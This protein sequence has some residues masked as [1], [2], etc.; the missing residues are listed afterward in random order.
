ME[1]VR[2]SG[3]WVE[4]GGEK[5]GT[6]RCKGKKERGDKFRRQRERGKDKER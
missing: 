1:D 3:G 5:M 4:E 2:F 6:E